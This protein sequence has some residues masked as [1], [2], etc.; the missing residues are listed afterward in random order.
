MNNQKIIYV[1]G[2]CFGNQTKDLS[3]R[4]MIICFIDTQMKNHFQIRVSFKKNGSSNQAE[5]LACYEG[6]RY[7]I[8]MGYRNLLLKTDS[9]VV[10]WWLTRGKVGKKINDPQ[11]VKKVIGSVKKMCGFFE[12]FKV[13]VVPREE[14][15]A[16]KVLE[17][18]TKGHRFV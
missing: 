7:A 18:R 5:I 9:Q 8:K 15:R 1:D 13:D 2:G 14:N 3:K 16:G 11:F 17:M 6:I 4:R 10:Y 12:E